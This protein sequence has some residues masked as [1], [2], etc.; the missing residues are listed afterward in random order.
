MLGSESPAE[1]TVSWMAETGDLEIT[2]PQSRYVFRLN[3][4]MFLAMGANVR[5][6]AKYDSESHFIPLC[7]LRGTGL[8]RITVPIRPHRCSHMRLRLEGEGMALLYAI[9]AVAEKG[10]E[11]P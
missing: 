3:L 5:I 7:S 1:K 9:T 11:H 8:R 6:S 2:S 4:S 10:S